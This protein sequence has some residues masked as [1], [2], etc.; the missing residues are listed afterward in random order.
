MKPPVGDPPI[1]TTYGVCNYQLILEPLLNSEG[2]SKE[3]RGPKDEHNDRDHPMTLSHFYTVY[4]DSDVPI[5]TKS[6]PARENMLMISIMREIFFSKGS[7]QQLR[8]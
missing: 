2:G 3:H 4:L 7:R 6:K 5:A 1:D 8:A